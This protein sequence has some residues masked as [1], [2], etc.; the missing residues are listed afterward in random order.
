VIELHD[1][2][3]VGERR[4]IVADAIDELREMTHL[5]EELVELARG[6][7]HVPTK[8]PTRLDHLAEEALA[9]A[10]RRSRTHFRTDLKATLVDGAPAALTRAISN[11][12]DNAVKWS[13]EGAPVEVTVKDGTV[14]VR[15]H[16]RGIDPADL[17]HVFDRF[18][19]APAARTLPGS[20]LGLA[21][22][23]QVAEAHGGAVTA[24]PADGGGSV[25]T[26]RLPV[27]PA[28]HAEGRPRTSASPIV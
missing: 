21:I 25:F 15:D 14:I 11:L 9:A 16:G 28:A 4:R 27:L 6:D 3:P 22:V 13:P 5:I 18:Y 8:Q 26:L 10:A 2:L 24:E 12:L 17:P 20:G 7:A 19:R 23:R 1:E